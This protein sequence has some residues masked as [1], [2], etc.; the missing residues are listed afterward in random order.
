MSAGFSPLGPIE[1]HHL[2]EVFVK[3]GVKIAEDFRHVRRDLYAD[4]PPLFRVGAAGHPR[5]V[6]QAKNPP[7]F[8]KEETCAS[9]E[10]TSSLLKYEYQISRLS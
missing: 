2:F 6:F 1:T 9:L 10:N 5:R 4:R 7:L 8:V 3:R